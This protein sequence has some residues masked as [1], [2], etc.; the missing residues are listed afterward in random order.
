MYVHLSITM[1]AKLCIL[2]FKVGKLPFIF[3][4]TFGGSPDTNVIIQWQITNNLFTGRSM[5]ERDS[6]FPGREYAAVTAPAMR[7]VPRRTAPTPNMGLSW[8]SGRTLSQPPAKSVAPLPSDQVCRHTK[9]AASEV[10]KGMMSDLP[11][12]FNFSTIFRNFWGATTIFKP[13]EYLMPHF[14]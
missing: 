4:L 6:V 2:L 5:W 9:F 14:F 1:C 8:G 12:W 11:P 3:Y 10:S 7:V 13:W